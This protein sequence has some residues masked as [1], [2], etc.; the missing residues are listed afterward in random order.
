MTTDPIASLTPLH[1]LYPRHDN[2]PVNVIIKQ[3]DDIDHGCLTLAEVVMLPEEATWHGPRLRFC[4]IREREREVNACLPDCLPDCLWA[5]RDGRVVKARF[6]DNRPSMH[7]ARETT[8]K[9]G[10]A[11]GQTFMFTIFIFIFNFI[12]TRTSRKLQ[13][14]IDLTDNGAELK[15][16]DDCCYHDDQKDN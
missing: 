4:S 6:A 11:A 5:G 3:A 1:P 10:P 9:G 13:L 15:R 8:R 2:Q 14:T 12:I 16:N 7:Q